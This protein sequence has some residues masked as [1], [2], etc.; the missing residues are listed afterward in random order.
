MEAK[1]HC[2]RWILK[3]LVISG[4]NM[5]KVYSCEITIKVGMKKILLEPEYYEGPILIFRAIDP[6]FRKFLHFQL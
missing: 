3:N 2:F 1:N 5:S 6:C 4:K